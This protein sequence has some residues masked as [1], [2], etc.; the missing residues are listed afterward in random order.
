[1]A[2]ALLP[3]AALTAMTTT[4]LAGAAPKRASI[5]TSA[6]SVAIGERARLSGS[7]P[8]ASNAAVEIRERAA[9]SKRWRIAA[10][11]KTGAAGR[12]QVRVEP[13]RSAFWRAELAG[14]PAPQAAP[15]D[16]AAALETPTDVDGGTGSERIAVRSRTRAAVAGRHAR[17]GRS[18]R[19]HGT[20]SPAGEKRRVIVRIGGERIP[21]RAGVGGRFEVS[22]R[23]PSTGVY[24]VRVNARSN[25]TATGSRDAAG[26][27][28]VYRPAVASWYGPGLYG[29]T[30]GC[31]GTLTP[32]TIGVAH[33][34]MP[35]GTRLHLRYRGRTI[36]ARVIDRGPYVGGREFDLTEATKRALGFPDTGIVLSSR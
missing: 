4:S 15:T 35:C 13:R 36:T 33:K 28:T 1:M 12:W 23:A 5:E 16:G 31:G 30:L 3:L 6:R 20:V 14:D 32:S 11:A 21:A 22:W 9:G 10:R 19:V 26:R 34:T 25:R 2:L 7:F 8:G 18:I 27:V 17:V 29:N 24:P